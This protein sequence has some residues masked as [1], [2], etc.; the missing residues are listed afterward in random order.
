VNAGEDGRKPCVGALSSGGSRASS[1]PPDPQR[2][3]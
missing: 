3:G 2:V 1:C